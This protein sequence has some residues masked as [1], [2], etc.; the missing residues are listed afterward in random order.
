[1]NLRSTLVVLSI[2]GGGLSLAQATALSTEEP[3]RIQV[4]ATDTAHKVFSVTEFI[5]LHGEASMTLLYPQWETGSHAPTISVA[6]LAGLELRV[7]GKLL[8]WHRDPLNVHAFHV[9]L[10]A[11]ASLLEA[12]F[13]YLSPF[14]GGVMTRNIVQVQ[15]E[16]LMLTPQGRNVNDI[17]VTAQ[18][19]FPEG[20]H[21]ASSLPV[22]QEDGAVLKF[23]QCTVGEL[24]DAP[25]FAGRFTKD[26]LL[27]KENDKP[28]RLHL[29][30]DAAKDLSISAGQLEELRSAVA[31]S[32]DMFGAAPFRHY[33]FLVSLSDLLPNDGG[34][35]HQES[36]EIY[37]P[38]DYFL[39][40]DKYKA[41]APLFPHE[42]IHAWNGL[43]HRAKGLLV[44][45]FNTPMKDGMLWVYEG[46]TELWG[47]QIARESGL[48]SDQDYRDILALDAAEQISRPGRRWKTLGDSD[49]DPVYL[50]GH[51]ITWRDWERR[52]DYYAEGPLLWL[53][54]DAKLRSLSNGKKSLKDFARAF[55]A[56]GHA[57]SMT[58]YTFPAVMATLNTIAPSS[59][60]DYFLLRLTTHDGSYLVDSLKDAG[61]SLVFEA[62]ENA[63][64]AQQEQEDEAVDL[65]YSIGARIRQNGVVQNV[66]WDSLAFNAGLAPGMKITAING[67]A[68][69]V[70]AL[71]QHLQDASAAPIRL[72]VLSEGEVEELSLDSRAGLRFPHLSNLK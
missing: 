7:K 62:T 50:A 5:P 67:E 21:A 57:P 43:S 15:W 70:T 52:E 51:H 37:L 23:Q 18:I 45:D 48:I 36:S 64:L 72:T 59:W 22:A 42:Y 55:F 35:E 47:L 4:D 41:L 54:V 60:Q 71:R 13:Q 69:S 12:H 24:A 38:A 29:V 34:S 32:N 66:S 2:L 31:R 30:A 26:W 14:R 10:P 68:F 46:L 1:M 49:Y 61:Y 17:P 8:E 28:V 39:A 33:D 56:S 65:S 3:L 6:D 44:P 11:K 9:T 20:F 25:I 63:I 58:T 53:G 27:S 40:P 19:K 16:H